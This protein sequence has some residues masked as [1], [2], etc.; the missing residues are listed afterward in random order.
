MTLLIDVGNSAVKWA[1]LAEGRIGAVQRQVHRDVP[2]LATRLADALRAPAADRAEVVA[3]NVA[4]AEVAR[5]V[6]EA[7]GEIGLGPIAWLRSEARFDAGPVLVNGY[8]EPEQLGA[9][10]WHAMLGACAVV[11]G[12]SFVIANAGTAT[13]VD[14]VR[15]DADGA[16]FIG[17]CIAPGV[18]LMLDSLARGTAGLPRAA[19]DAADFPDNTEAAIITGV[20]DA[21]AGLVE[22]VWRRFADS[23]RTKPRL[24]LAGGHADALLDRLPR[25][26]A[27]L[28][29]HNLVLR[30]LALR[31]RQ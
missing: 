6:E 17:G 31:V 3:C 2:D 5:A 19:G 22:R 9:D 30:G 15:S 28:I 24:L 18:R 10:R 20:L 14:C 21:Q 23:I 8:R 25:E 26:T 11:P 27:G 16:R 13:T 7:V 4:S 1:W 12:S 29:E